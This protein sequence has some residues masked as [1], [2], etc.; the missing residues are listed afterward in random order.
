MSFIVLFVMFPALN[1]RRTDHCGQ[2]FIGAGLVVNGSA[3]EAND[4]PWMVA[5][6]YLYKDYEYFCAGNLV[7]TRHV[8]SGKFNTYSFIQ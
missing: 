3:T 4:W 5:L 2:R 6:M 7:T 1:G 8:L